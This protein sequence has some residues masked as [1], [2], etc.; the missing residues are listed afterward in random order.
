MRI[1]E[2]YGLKSN[3][4]NFRENLYTFF[5]KTLHLNNLEIRNRDIIVVTSK[6]VS[7]S[8]G[9]IKS[10][11]SVKPSVEG[12][13]LAKKYN[14]PAAL[15]ELILREADEII[16]GIKGV[17]YTLKDGILIA[18]AGI[19]LSNVPKGY[20]VLH[21]R[22]PWMVA[23]NF[24][25]EILRRTG[26]KKV[27][28]LIVDSKTQPLRKGNIGVALAV[29]G[30]KPVIDERGKED[31][32]GKKMKFTRRAVADNLACIAELYLKERN[33]LTPFVLVRE[34]PVEFCEGTF[35]EEMKISREEDLF[36]SSFSSYFR[37]CS[38]I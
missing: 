30:F 8:Q 37:N 35:S 18:N 33:E 25:E 22:K 14:I 5:F 9:R 3:V 34:A 24:R 28:I 17:V 38:E 7:V 23:K 16:G 13:R 2:V 19:D 32:Y 12:E 15:A 21:P 6:V 4:M 27:G 11:F 1:V 20:A 10:L 31:L 29:S 26:R 36:Y